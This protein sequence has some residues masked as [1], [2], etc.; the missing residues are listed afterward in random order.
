MD[1]IHE[2]SSDSDIRPAHSPVEIPS[3]TSSTNLSLEMAIKPSSTPI[4]N[5]WIFSFVGIRCF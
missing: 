2:T 5:P 1:R 4:K 3:D